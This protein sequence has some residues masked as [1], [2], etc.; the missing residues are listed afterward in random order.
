[1]ISCQGLWGK[2]KKREELKDIFEIGF[3]FK[4]FYS[5][6][7]KRKYFIKYFNIRQNVEKGFEEGEF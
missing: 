1:M 4:E 6:V 2:Q 3:V 5:L 7:K